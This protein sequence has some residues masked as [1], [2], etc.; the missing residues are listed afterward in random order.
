MRF[1]C[2]LR[3]FFCVLDNFF[4]SSAGFSSGL[5]SGRSIFR[6]LFISTFDRAFWSTGEHGWMSVSGFDFC[7]F[8]D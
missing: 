1:F 6:V 3:S 7:T 2:F 8:C 5:G 4:C